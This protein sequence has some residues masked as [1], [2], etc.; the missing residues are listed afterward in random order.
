[1]WMGV[2]RLI[3]EYFVPEGEKWSW[4]DVE[5]N[6]EPNTRGGTR[7]YKRYLR[8]LSESFRII[9]KNM[10]CELRLLNIIDDTLQDTNYTY[11]TIIVLNKVLSLNTLWLRIDLSNKR[12]MWLRHVQDVIFDSWVVQG[13]NHN[14]P[15]QLAQLLYAI[16]KS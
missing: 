10:W 11:C 4:V 2:G 14:R 8:W 5:W 7:S 16:E 6:S 1:M 15:M 13:V 12:S 3:N 9:E